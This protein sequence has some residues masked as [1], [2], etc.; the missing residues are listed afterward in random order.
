MMNFHS[1]FLT[2][3]GTASVQD[4]VRHV[5]YLV[6]RAGIEH[7]AL[8]SDFEGDIR[9]PTGLGD[10]SRFPVLAQALLDAGFENVQVAQI[11]HRNALRVLC[12]RQCSASAP[13]AKET[14]K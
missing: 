3:S 6:R 2:E 11:F 1:R 9:A 12:P 5:R 14:A 4:V 8:G 13:A 7:V 10:A